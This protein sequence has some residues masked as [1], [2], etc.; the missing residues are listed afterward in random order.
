VEESKKDL[1]IKIEDLVQQQF[2][3]IESEKR[4]LEN[5]F[6]IAYFLEKIHEVKTKIEAGMELKK[7]LTSEIDQFRNSIQE[8]EGKLYKE[9]GLEFFKIGY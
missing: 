8:K 1:K 3:L 5:K 7:N 9:V 2:M 6:N 4:H